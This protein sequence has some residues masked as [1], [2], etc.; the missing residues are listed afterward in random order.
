M[1]M[2]K[3]KKE[4]KEVPELTIAEKLKQVFDYYGVFNRAE[5]L[6][7]SK[8]LG[9]KIPPKNIPFKKGGYKPVVKVTKENAVCKNADFKKD[10]DSVETN[11]GCKN[12]RQNGS[13]RCLD[14]KLN[15]K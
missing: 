12:L 13:S 9:V 5:R 6:K 3:N 14:C 10:K 15:D 8:M 7:W 11:N 2:L 1:K 4:I